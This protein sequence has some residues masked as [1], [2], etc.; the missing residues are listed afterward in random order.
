MKKKK[1]S[2]VKNFLERSDYCISTCEWIADRAFEI[3]NKLDQLENNKF[4]KSYN[5]KHEAYIKELSY[6][7]NKSKKEMETMDALEKE[8][9]ILKKGK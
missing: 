3:L 7:L 4:D 9:H 5:K 8:L 1:L 2:K 6:F